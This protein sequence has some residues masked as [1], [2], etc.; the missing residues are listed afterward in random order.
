MVGTAAVC[1]GSSQIFYPPLR[2]AVI[3]LV[4]LCAR[5]ALGLMH[6]SV[7]PHVGSSTRHHKRVFAKLHRRSTTGLH[8]TL[9]VCVTD[10]GH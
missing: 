9:V 10:I 1:S 8:S 3:R 7:C 2:R 6:T 5:E 4:R